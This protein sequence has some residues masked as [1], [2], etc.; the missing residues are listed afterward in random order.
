MPTVFPADVKQSY[1]YL[2]AGLLTLGLLAFGHKMSSMKPI[3]MTHSAHLPAS[4]GTYTQYEPPSI[5]CS[6]YSL[7]CPVPFRR[8]GRDQFTYRCSFSCICAVHSRYGPF[9]TKL[10]QAPIRSN[11]LPISVS[12]STLQMPLLTSSLLFLTLTPGSPRTPSNVWSWG[13]DSRMLI[14]SKGHTSWTLSASP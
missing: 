4:T 13:A 8:C 12:S 14:S 3:R 10:L 5:K 6:A 1:R 11:Y 9:L 7:V 2:T